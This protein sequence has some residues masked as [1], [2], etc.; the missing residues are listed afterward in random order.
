MRSC[1]DD[2]GR[3]GAGIK[4][5]GYY[6]QG[7]IGQGANAYGVSNTTIL[8]PASQVELL[9]SEEDQVEGED[10]RVSKAVRSGGIMTCQCDWGRGS[11][12]PSRNTLG[13]DAVSSCMTLLGVPS[14]TRPI[15]SLCLIWFH[16]GYAPGSGSPWLGGEVLRTPRDARGAHAQD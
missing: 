3:T 13:K 5:P 9:S 12:D 15:P 16:P 8:G 4:V 7:N 11:L 10:G 1:G 6:V 2:T 14:W